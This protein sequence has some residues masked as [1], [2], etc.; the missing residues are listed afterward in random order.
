MAILFGIVHYYYWNTSIIKF[1]TDGTFTN[2]QLSK[3]SEPRSGPKSVGHH[4]DHM[5]DIDGIPW[6]IFLFSFRKSADDKQHAFFLFYPAC[7][8]LFKFFGYLQAIDTLNYFIIFPYQFQY[9]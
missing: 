3:Q 2:M 9:V 6:K 1:K 7:K 5:F 4:L 8:Q